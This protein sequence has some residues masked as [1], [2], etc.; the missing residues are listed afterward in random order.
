M[1]IYVDIDGTICN[2]DNG[3]ENAIPIKS[4]IEKI[5]K[6]YDNGHVIIYWTARG[7]VTGKNWKDLTI[8]QLNKWGCKYHDVI[9]GNKP[10]YDL[11]IDDKT[12]KI[13][14]L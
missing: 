10:A 8:L 3:Y 4:N 5:N 14:D 9:M 1:L 13:D 7:Q 12:I 6:L 11:L 2:S